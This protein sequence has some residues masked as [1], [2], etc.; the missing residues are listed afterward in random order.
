MAGAAVEI[1]RDELLWFFKCS[2]K[3]PLTLYPWCCPGPWI[4]AV[5]T[6]RMHI[7]PMV[8]SSC[9]STLPRLE[10]SH[11]L[12]KVAENLDNSRGATFAAN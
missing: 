4:E 12:C 8:F 3:P 10:S 5:R 7:S 9:R 6:Y 11:E 1:Q 2:S